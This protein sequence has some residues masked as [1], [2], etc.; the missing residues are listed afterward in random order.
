MGL[1]FSSR[2]VITQSELTKMMNEIHYARD[3]GGERLF[4][5]HQRNYLTEEY[6]THLDSDAPGQPEG[7]TYEEAAE[8][9][10]EVR[11]PNPIQKDKQRRYQLKQEFTPE[12]MDYLRQVEE[13]YL[14]R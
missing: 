12:Q 6:N 4:S 14:N 5:D 8:V 11:N 13:K 1:F 2:P 7:I 9:N 10:E 3:K